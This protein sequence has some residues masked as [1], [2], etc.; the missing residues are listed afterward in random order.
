MDQRINRRNPPEL[1]VPLKPI[2]PAPS[3]ASV[4]NPEADLRAAVENLCA[5]FRAH[6]ILG[7][8]FVAN[9]K[10]DN[11]IISQFTGGNGD[12]HALACMGIAGGQRLRAELDKKMA[13]GE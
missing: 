8:V 4:A 5:V 7:A 12:I 3:A 1:Q 6:G 9:R 2:E 11:S 13:G 10:A